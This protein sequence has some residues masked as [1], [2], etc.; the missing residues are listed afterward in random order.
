[1]DS[2]ETCEIVVPDAS[3]PIIK[4]ARSLSL[5]LQV[6]YGSKQPTATA[7]SDCGAAAAPHCGVRQDPSRQFSSPF[8]EREEFSF[9]GKNFLHETKTLC[10][11]PARGTNDL[12]MLA[13]FLPPFSLPTPL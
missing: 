12:A 11:R 5:S 8:S 7:A 13:P 4:A 1:M 9:I 2:F 3:R 6:S 10:E